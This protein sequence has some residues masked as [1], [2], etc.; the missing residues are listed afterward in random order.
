MSVPTDPIPQLPS[1]EVMLLKWAIF[2]ALG[3]TMS[4]PY[5]VDPL[6][7]YPNNEIILM[8]Y[9][10]S[11]IAAGGGGGG[12][13]GDVVGP[14]LAVD[15]Q[16]AVFDGVTGKLIKDGGK[17][18]A[19]LA[20]LTANTFTGQQI[21][22]LNGA[23]STPPDTLTGTWFTG[24]SA[25][26]TKPQFLIEPTG[27]TSTGWSTA[28]TGVGV[29]APAAFAGKLADFQVAGVRAL[30]VNADGSLLMAGGNAVEVW[31]TVAT[32]SN[33][34]RALH[35]NNYFI[36]NDGNG[37]G[38][39]T[40]TNTGGGVGQFNIGSK[41]SLSSSGNCATAL[42]DV[43]LF[44]KA[45]AT[46]Q[47]G[48]DAAGVT[49]QTFTAANRIT[50]DGVGANLTIAGGNGRGG[51]G[52]SLILGAYQTAGAGTAGTFSPIITLDTS[53]GATFVN[54]ST[55]TMDNVILS[56]TSNQGFTIGAATTDLLSFFGGTRRAQ[57]AGVSAPT[58][59][60][61]VG[62]DLIDVAGLNT[63]IGS[64]QTAI[65]DIIARLNVATGCS[66]IAN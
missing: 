35:F 3:G 13:T 63:V 62:L 7:Q 57:G 58:G 15:S 44:A 20:V 55:L 50:S 21:I 27:T 1:N 29:N 24:G 8:K 46:L 48:I 41:L 36:L 40:T 42:G 2:V 52:G 14:A 51:A 12:G 64:I 45:A 56:A 18:I 22:S 25:T 23:A 28:G 60:A 9:L 49:N 31:N 26:T 32:G 30:S 38:L 37:N 47:M 39:F 17:T 65:T 43:P 5:D 34:S 10:I 11:A 53:L 61:S 16:I 59:S 54:G 33:G 4:S 19:Q 6:P 66:L